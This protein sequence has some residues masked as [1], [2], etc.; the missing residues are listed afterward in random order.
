MAQKSMLSQSFSWKFGKNDIASSQIFLFRK[1]VIGF[2]NIK[3]IVPGH[4]LVS[5]RKG[6]TRLKE[7]NEIET[8]DLWL[9]V[10]EV[11]KVIEDIYKVL[12]ASNFS[13]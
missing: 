10:A 8:C 4:V 11:Q 13:Y 6:V 12:S 9:S 5:P 7:L 2:V 1:N 3:P